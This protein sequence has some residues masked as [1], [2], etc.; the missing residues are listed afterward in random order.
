MNDTN[1]NARLTTAAGRWATGSGSAKKDLVLEKLHADVDQVLRTAGWSPDRRVDTTPY[2][3]CI[4][5]KRWTPGAAALLAE[6]GGLKLQWA[7]WRCPK[8][9]REGFGRIAF[10]PCDVLLGVPEPFLRRC[11]RSWGA[12]LSAIG[13]LGDWITYVDPAGNIVADN[14]AEDLLWHHGRSVHEAI[15]RYVAGE[16]PIESKPILPYDPILDGP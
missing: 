1:H 9:G 16:G 3:S 2:R 6:L 7:A 4:G 15:R 5:E 13:E 12:T 8:T 11:E 14:W 10:D